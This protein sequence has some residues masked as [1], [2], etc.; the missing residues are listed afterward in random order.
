MP[1]VDVHPD[2]LRELTG[3]ED[4]SDEEFKEDLFA[5]GLEFEGETEDGEF[6]LEFGPDR[7]DRLSV[8]GVARSLRYQYG[9]ERGV[10]VPNTNN[11]DYTFVVDE[12]VPEER[13]YV[14]GAIVRGVDLDEAALDSLIQLQE[15]L[16][17]TM[18]RKRAKGAIGIHDLTMIKG[19]VLQEDTGGNSITYTG[20][21]PDEDTFVP[22]DSDAELSPGEV[23]ERHP[24]GREYAELVSEYDRYPA[25]YDELGLF[26]FPPVINGRRTEV[27]TESR[28]LLVEL[29]GTDQW[30]IDRMCNIICYALSARGATI[31]DVEVQYSDR[32]LVRP[33]FE[34]DTKHVSHDRIETMLGVEFG[35]REVA[36]LFERS[37][38]GVTRAESDES[39]AVN[40]EDGAATPT[41]DADEETV[42]EVSVP[43]YRVDVLHPSDLVDDVGRAYGFN[44]LEP[45]YPDVGTVGKR[46]ERS[47]LEDAA[48]N[49][50]V[51][52]GF[53]DMLNFHMTN[54]DALTT[55]MN[56]EEG[57]SVPA[58]EASGGSSE[59]R[60]DGVL[61]GGEPARITEPYSED[62]TVLRTWALP[63]LLMV[64]ENNTHRAYPQD[65]AEIGLVAERDDDVNTRVRERRHVAAVLARHDATYED[66]KA[67]LQ[68]L[69]RDF[70]VELETPKTTHPSFIDGRVASVVVDGDDVGVVGEVHPSVL[71]EHD[72]ELPVAAFEFDLSAL[73]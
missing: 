23:L 44:E 6:Q 49:T 39:T 37:G 63:S 11:P 20:I 58:S 56:V 59:R 9:D 54:E 65:L 13:P 38:L 66:A 10:Y 71:V 47:R 4:K 69:C 41:D 67:R 55:R 14:T 46:H 36:D 2:E 19:D 25:I 72:L 27:S 48:R 70:D 73:R 28:E 18:G 52:L 5:L 12:D 42:Y 24:T 29:T 8:E 16:H 60:S 35:E 34:V 3:H 64:L 62:Y 17:A 51:G 32:T 40:T 53:E 1:V 50:L 57:E 68:T 22:L 45:R 30:T 43:P 15:K 7:L 31:E 26:S 33:D 61:G 21:A